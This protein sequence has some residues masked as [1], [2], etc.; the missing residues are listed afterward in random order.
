LQRHYFR[1]ALCGNVARVK[2]VAGGLGYLLSM[3]R[4][5]PRLVGLTFATLVLAAACGSG[6][7][8][9]DATE[10]AENADGGNSSEPVPLV[11]PTD[12]SGLA[13]L[14]SDD[15]GDALAH[16]FLAV[17]DAKNEEGERERTRVSVVRSAIDES[18]MGWQQLRDLQFPE[19]ELSNDLESVARVPDRNLV[20]L[21]ESG[22]GGDKPGDTSSDDAAGIYVAAFTLADE[23]VDVTLSSYTP[24]PETPSPLVNVEATAVAAGDDGQLWFLYAERASGQDAT[25]INWTTLDIADDGA[26]TF[27][28]DWQSVPFT[29]PG[30]SGA[31]PAASLEV[32]PDGKVYVAAAWD[33]DD[34]N[35]PYESAVWLVGTWDGAA[36]AIEPLDEPVQVCRADGVKIESIA[37]AGDA[38]DSAVF[39]GVDDENY[40]ATLRSLRPLQP[41]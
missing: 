38:D 40:G 35:G 16:F 18:G 25:T 39:V 17:H 20:L 2:G 24:W 10:R 3:T 31:R 37:V 7:D 21:V 11:V 27:G 8:G 14:A 30:P 6:T 1:T 28:S 15:S 22:D 41:R 23:G 5:R 12:F 4:S 29:R 13:W 32:G 19:R 36:A 26:V 34:D 33:P 9:D